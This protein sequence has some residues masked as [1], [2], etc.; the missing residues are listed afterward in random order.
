[1]CGQVSAPWG[2]INAQRWLYWTTKSKKGENVVEGAQLTSF[3]GRRR[4]TSEKRGH[5]RSHAKYGLGGQKDHSEGRASGTVGSGP[6]QR[7]LAAIQPWET[8]ESGENELFK[9]AM[10]NVIEDLSIIS[11]DKNNKFSIG[12]GD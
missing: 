10:K 12:R 5:L 3:R 2:P 1:M 11:R 9:R 6:A 8:W 4:E 7:T